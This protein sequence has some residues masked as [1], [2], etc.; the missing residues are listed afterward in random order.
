MKAPAS[1]DRDE[2]LARAWKMLRALPEIGV[3]F[4]RRYE[5]GDYLLDFVNPKRRFVIDVGGEFSPVRDAYLQSEGFF[6]WRVEPEI[7]FGDRWVKEIERLVLARPEQSYT[8]RKARVETP[9]SIAD[10]ASLPFWKTKT[11]TQM[12]DAEWESLC[13]G[14]GK[15]CLIGLEDEETG[16]IHLTDVACKLFDGES[17]QCS[18]YA[19]RKA[20][21]PDCV[22]LTPENVPELY[23]LPKTCGYRLVAAGQDLRSWHPLISGDPQSVHTANVSVRGKTRKEKSRQSMRSLIEAITKWPDDER[24]K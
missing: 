9:V 6:V 5:L 2:A 10:D 3:Q 11:L 22:K 15:C 8:R 4:Q 19:N 23:W 16:V 14:C 1:V 20:K 17:C 13:D 18:D 24:R 7:V 12:S 21:V